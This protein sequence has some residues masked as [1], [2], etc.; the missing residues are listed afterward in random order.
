[1]SPDTAVEKTAVPK[2][3]TPE[4][5]E[6]KD[7]AAV[8][9]GGESGSVYVVVCDTV[10]LPKP[11]VRKQTPFTMTVPAPLGMIEIDSA[12][13]PLAVVTPTASPPVTLVMSDKDI[14]IETAPSTEK[15]MGLTV[16]LDVT[17]TLMSGAVTTTL[18][19][20]LCHGP[21]ALASTWTVMAGTRAS[22]VT[23]REYTRTFT[24]STLDTEPSVTKKELSLVFRPATG[25]EKDTVIR[26]V[27]SDVPD[28]EMEDVTVGGAGEEHASLAV[29]PAPAT[30]HTALGSTDTAA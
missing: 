11:P 13:P 2:K 15:T 25:D 21:T 4:G 9:V 10:R 28:T 24:R 20:L 17:L 29:V 16:G 19:S 22:G 12:N 8:M 30:I 1:M 3:Y 5:V 27:A 26:I 6:P 7:S 18:A 14:A 23:Q